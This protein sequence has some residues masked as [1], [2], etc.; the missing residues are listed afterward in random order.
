MLEL[1]HGFNSV[2]TKCKLLLFK[3]KRLS[4]REELDTN[5][6]LLQRRF[7]NLCNFYYLVNKETELIPIKVTE[8]I[9]KINTLAESDK[10]KFDIKDD[11][12][13]LIDLT[14]FILGFQELKVFASLFKGTLSNIDFTGDKHFIN[15]KIIDLQ[16][17]DSVK[18]KDTKE[19]Q[20]LRWNNIVNAFRQS[21]GK[22]LET[23]DKSKLTFQFK[24][25]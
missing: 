11:Q 1:T 24:A 14:V 13:I 4:I 5:L 20:K 10:V 3:L 23:K 17:V 2:L 25:S 6:S 18:D 15:M 21:G 7:Y 12:T 16:D 8:V 22:V 19:E 9:E